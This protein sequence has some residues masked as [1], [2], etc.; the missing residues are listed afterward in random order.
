MPHHIWE[1]G[2]GLAFLIHLEQSGQID[3]VLLCQPQLLLEDVTVPVQA[4]LGGGEG[5]GR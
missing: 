4:A 2:S 1:V 3:D 5:E